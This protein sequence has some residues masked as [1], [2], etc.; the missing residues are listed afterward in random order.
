MSTHDNITTAFSNIANAIRIRNGTNATY[1]PDQ[2]PAAINAITGLPDDYC[3]IADGVRR[4][5][6]PGQADPNQASYGPVTIGNNVVSCSRLFHN[7]LNFNQPVTFPNS[8]QECDYAFYRCNALNQPI[9]LSSNTVNCSNMF[10]GCHSFNQPITIPQS[11]NTV[12]MMF[13]LCDHMTSTVRIPNKF[14]NGKTTSFWSSCP[15]S[16][17]NGTLI[18]Y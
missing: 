14:N 12:S 8:V 5:G 16:V 10:Y 7:C 6:G 9:V 17:A 13:S 1:T 2:M 18:F 3:V 4:C 15:V 11:V